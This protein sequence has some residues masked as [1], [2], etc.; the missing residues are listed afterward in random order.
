VTRVKHAIP[1]ATPSGRARGRALGSRLDELPPR[2]DEGDLLVVVE[3]PRGSSVKLK[4]DPELGAMTL[5]R[6]LVMG[7][8]MA[9]DFGFVPGTK[10]EDGDPLDAIVLLDAPTAPGV[11][12]RCRPIG[13]VGLTQKK[14]SQ[15]KEKNGGARERNDRIVAVAC[16]DRRRAELADA[17]DLPERDRKEI[18]QFFCAAA[19]LEGKELEVLGWRGAKDAREAV[20]EASDALRRDGARPVRRG[21]GRGRRG[22]SR[23]SKDRDRSSRAM[24]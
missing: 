2:D 15:K 21:G 12:V 7:S 18:E 13:V 4:Y 8:V 6:P 5:S 10:A 17:R 24:R 22:R 23:G 9:F 19:A 11:V 14:A 16:A 3:S 20:D 1:S